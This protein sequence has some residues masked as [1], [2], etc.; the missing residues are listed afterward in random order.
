MYAAERRQQILEAARTAGRVD[1]LSLAADLEVTAETI[2]RDLTALERLG[3]LR[4]V[5]GGAMPIDR[6]GF[7]PDITERESV[8]AGA[9]DRIARAALDELPEGG[10]V[11][12]DAGTTTIRL[13]ALL[14]S[15]KKLTVVTHALPVATVVSTMPNISLHLLGGAVRGTT[16]AAVGDWTT[17][18]LQDVTVDVAFLGTNGIADTGLSTPDLAEAAVK[19]A[20]VGAARRTVLLADH[21]KFGR[22]EFARVVGLEEIDTVITD[23]D[24]DDE[25]YESIEA[26]GPTVVRT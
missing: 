15:E 2:R 11:I 26:C 22:R 23:T 24:L 18:C 12:L 4:R 14:P 17:R 19:R 25:M 3:V 6:F 20:L 7:E 16:L 1:V 8:E 9:K 5:H 10:S 13:A 21:T